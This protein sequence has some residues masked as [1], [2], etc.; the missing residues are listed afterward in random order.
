YELIR[1]DRAVTISEQL[2]QVTV[3]VTLRIPQ[4]QQGLTSVTWYPA[5]VMTVGFRMQM[6]TKGYVNLNSNYIPQ[7]LQ[8]HISLIRDKSTQRADTTRYNPLVITVREMWKNPW[9]TVNH[10]ELNEL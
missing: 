5:E 7:G 6:C 2:R 3:K 8:Q 9:P 1:S 10:A 4:W